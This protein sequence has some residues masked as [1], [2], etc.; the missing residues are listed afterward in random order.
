MKATINFLSMRELLLIVISSLLFL[1][2]CAVQKP[3]QAGTCVP[4]IMVIAHRGA[5]NNFPENSISSIREAIEIGVDIVEIDI[6]HTKDGHLILMHDK[7]IDRTTNGVGLVEDYTLNEIKDFRL[8]NTDGTLTDERIPT[9]EEV[10][11]EFGFITHFDL[12]IKTQKYLSVIEMIEEY[13]LLESSLF[14]VYD[15]EVAKMLKK[16]NKLF[17][18]LMR[19]GDEESVKVIFNEFTPEAVHIDDSLNSTLVNETIKNNGS[20]SFINSLG[21]ID[22]EAKNN[23]DAF[24]K[25]YRNGANM[26]QTDYPEQLLRHLRSRKLHK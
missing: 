4:E 8:R 7:T 19:A 21:V 23:P 15:L 12:D 5:H 13:D 25:A 2:S 18:I 1:Q 3:Q 22:N 10:L 20:W 14:L 9:L 16:R 6:Q 24:E 11:T 17:K 26:V